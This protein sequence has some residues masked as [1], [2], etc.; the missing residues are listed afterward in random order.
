MNSRDVHVE[1]G[2]AAYDVTIELG[3]LSRLGTLVAAVTRGPGALLA[4]DE[5]I[6]SDHG[7]VAL[8]SLRDAG[9]TET[10]TVTLTAEESHKTLATAG[11]VY[12]SMLGADRPLERGSPV[13]ALGGGIVGDTA[14]FAAAT[15]MR[16]LPLV[17]VPTTL[18]AMVDAAIGGKTGVNFDLPGGGL[19]KNLIGAFWQPKAVVVDPLVLGTLHP[20]DLRCGLAECVKYA[21]IADASLLDFLEAHAAALLALETESLMTLIERCVRIKAAIVAEDEL[22]TGRRALLNLGHTFA[23]A[24][25]SRPEAG[26]RH[27]EAVAVGLV[28]A[29]HCALRR[30]G[31]QRRDVQ[32]IVGVLESL[33]LPRRLPEPIGLDAL[34]QA[35]RYDKKT[36]GGRMRLIMSTALGSAEITD[37][38]SADVIRAAWEE[39]GATS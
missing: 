32:R 9:F 22:E 31:L 19:G 21:L 2:D 4:V 16:G 15:F 6:A 28:A 20:R 7:E 3:S 10:I 13:I 26:L 24:I 5:R 36:L 39:V 33:G 14:G 29:S 35:M 27:G 12:E 30:G 17:Q 8:N 1:L 18:L 34:T 23:H 38:V 11:R 37:E 25:E